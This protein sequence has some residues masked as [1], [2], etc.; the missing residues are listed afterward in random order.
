MS[1]TIIFPS[2]L[3]NQ[4]LSKKFSLHSLSLS[5]SY[6]ILLLLL[7]FFIFPKIHH[8]KHTLRDK[9]T[10]NDTSLY[11]ITHAHLTFTRRGTC[12]PR[13]KILHSRI[14]LGS[15]ALQEIWENISYCHTHNKNEEKEA[16]F[17]MPCLQ[18][19]NSC[20]KWDLMIVCLFFNIPKRSKD[21]ENGWK[22]GLQQQ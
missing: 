8:T 18:N 7:L 17:M 19:L 11:K 22:L 20:D 15:G 16:K 4:I 9:Q 3:P 1:P 14:F 21:N 6:F 2:F 10:T 12:T 5:L 13:L